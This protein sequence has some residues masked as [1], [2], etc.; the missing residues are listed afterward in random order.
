MLKVIDICVLTSWYL[1]ITTLHNIIVLYFSRGF[2]I[3]ICVASSLNLNSCAMFIKRV[4][5]VNGQG[6]NAG[7]Y[8]GVQ[9]V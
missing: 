3:D 9:I 2:K 6:A 7:Y 5:I 1:E 4:V 8:V